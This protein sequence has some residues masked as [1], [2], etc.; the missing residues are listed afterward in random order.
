[1]IKV[2]YWFY[3]IVFI[4][5]AKLL[6][7]VAQVFNPKIKSGLKGRKKLFENLIIDL[8]G[9]DRQ[10]KMIWF[11]SSS[12]GE[13]EQA[14]PIIEKLKAEKNV[15]VLV[16]FFSPSGY[17][18]SLK[19]PYADVIAYFPFDT[20]FA[21][22]R[23]LNLV[24][25]SIAV[26]MRY[27][28]WPNMIWQ[29]DHKKIPA[30]IVDATMRAKT[31]RKWFFI[32]SFHKALYSSF[33]KILTVSKEDVR[34]FLLFGLELKKIIAV[35]DTRFD[36][37][38]QKSLQAKTKVLFRD[39][40]FDDKK[41]FVF[42]SSWEND[43]EVVLPALFKLMENDQKIISII[44]PHEPT[45]VHI[46]QLENQLHNKFNSIRFSLLN[47]Y[48]NERVIIID[49]IGVLLTLYYYAHVAYVGGSF[50]QGIHNVLE[51]AVYGIP[52][53]FGPKHENSQEALKLVSLGGGI[54][55]KNKK[56][57]YRIL[58]KL[59]SDEKFRQEKGKVCSSYVT[60]NIGATEKIL[61]AIYEIL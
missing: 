3:N 48:N 58:R 28:I 14:K 59:F 32:K 5:L 7:F 24:R 53:V 1:M 61:Q 52:V 36:R 56:D 57:A 47:N 22:K 26:F 9:L 60:E 25:P 30:F 50:K 19:Y 49:S 38:Y 41:V 46:E 37:V 43:E 27:D 34:N 39:K 8:T 11:H 10:K 13:F 55:I 51:P 40:F 18:N 42:G 20:T 31:P 29:L 54:S 35:G 21:A 17:N 45:I 16:T 2:W 33:S 12:M 6:V 4:P 44:V 15:N 23:F